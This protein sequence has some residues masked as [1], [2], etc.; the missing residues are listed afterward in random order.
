MSLPI[1]KY[2]SKSKRHSKIRN[3]SR[4]RNGFVIE[5]KNSLYNT[6]RIIEDVIKI[7]FGSISSLVI[8]PKPYSSWEWIKL[9]DTTDN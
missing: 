2:D 6:A 9:I 3:T 5:P 1:R 4:T 7:N 8:I